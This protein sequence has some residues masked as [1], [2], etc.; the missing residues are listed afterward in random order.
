MEFSIVEESEALVAN[1]KALRARQ[2]HVDIRP[3]QID[4]F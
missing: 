2:R 1:A 3:Q 4:S